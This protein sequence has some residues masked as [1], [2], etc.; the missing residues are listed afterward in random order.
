VFR[1][2]GYGTEYLLVSGAGGRL[3]AVEKGDALF[4]AGKQQ[5]ELGYMRLE[6]FGDG[7]VLLTVVTD[8]TAECEGPAQGCRPEP[9]I[10]YW[11]WLK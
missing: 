8:G 5:R 2:S 4:A 11:S 7:T 10:R 1:G 3:K 9:M 6:F